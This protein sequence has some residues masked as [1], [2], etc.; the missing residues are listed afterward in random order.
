[1]FNAIGLDHF[2]KPKGPADIFICGNDA[3]AKKTATEIALAF[4]YSR[5]ID[6]GG[7]QSCRFLEPLGAL[8]VDIPMIGGN[9][10]TALLTYAP[11][12]TLRIQV[13]A[14]RGQTRR[15]AWKLIDMDE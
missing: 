10:F 2:Y 14:F 5:V 1:M 15:H 9:C 7:I 8:W 12:T 11:V 3:V 6:V 13:H 4:G